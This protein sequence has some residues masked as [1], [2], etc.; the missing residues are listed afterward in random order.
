MKKIFTF[1]TILTIV[2]TAG[3]QSGSQIVQTVKGKVVDVATN[4]GVP[5]TNISIE[6][7]FYG[8]A[9]NEDGEFELKI[10]EEMSGGQIQFSAVGFKARKFPVA[11]LFNR[12][13]NIIKLEPTS[14]DIEDVDIAAQSKVLERI[15]RMASENT[16]YNFIGGPFNLV[17]KYKNVKTVDDTTEIKQDAEILIY[18]Q[19]GYSSPS[20]IN[21]FRMRKYEVTPKNPIYS[22]SDGILNLDELLSLDWVRSASSVM[23]PSMLFRFDV[24]LEDE[25]EINGSPAWV[26]SFSQPEP[27]LAGA[28]DFYSTLFSGQITIMKDDYSVAKIEGNATSAKHNRQGKSLA[29]GS[30]NTNFYEDVSYDFSVTY[31]QL[32]PEVISLNKTYTYNGKKVE[33]KTTLTIEK[34]HT[35]DVKEIAARNYFSE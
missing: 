2:L 33:E 4:E 34:V 9:S 23:N 26:I 29:V 30:S 5:F 18:D 25:V 17:C 32:K 8:T 14:Y 13:F 28:D 7:T 12:E 31:R 24:Q 1:L 16:P 22:F 10:P 21:A 3:A 15:L 19:T 6:G 35:A 27:S 11:Q 20:E